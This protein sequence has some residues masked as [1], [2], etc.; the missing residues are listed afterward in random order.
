MSGLLHIVL[1]I[2]QKH[3]KFLLTHE[4]TGSLILLLCLSAKKYNGC[5]SQIFLLK[6]ILNLEKGQNTIS[7]VS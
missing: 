5:L 2:L 1:K 6:E 4:I 3:L 7:M